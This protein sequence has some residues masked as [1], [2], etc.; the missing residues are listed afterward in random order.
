MNTA[1]G[2]VVARFKVND[3]EKICFIPGTGVCKAEVHGEQIW[4]YLQCGIILKINI[5][6]KKNS[7]LLDIPVLNQRAYVEISGSQAPILFSSDSFEI[8]LSSKDV[9]LIRV[10]VGNE[11]DLN[12]YVYTEYFSNVELN[13]L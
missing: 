3:V 10:Y 5:V 13:I 7:F 9:I 8:T 6:A 1:D 11:G 12:Y 2:K 4:I